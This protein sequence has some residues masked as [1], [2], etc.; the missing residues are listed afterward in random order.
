MFAKYLCKPERIVACALKTYSEIGGIQQFN[1]RVF[2]NLARRSADKKDG[3][4]LAILSGDQG[5][6]PP[7][8][9]GIEF[10]VP[11]NQVQFVATALWMSVFRAKALI[12]CHVNLLPLA[13]AVRQFRPRLPIVL[14]VH[15]C[16]VWNIDRP[17][18]IRSLETLFAR[19]A[20]RIAAVSRFT[21][22]CMAREY[23]IAPDKFRILPNAVDR[24]HE[25]PAA[26]A[27]EPRTILT[28]ARL[29]LTERQKNVHF[30][31]AA[32]AVLR[33]RLPGVK[34]EIIGG[35]AL[36]PELQALAERLEVADAVT[37]FGQVG[38]REVREAYARA[39]VFAMP[40]DK[41]GFGIVYLE[42]WQHAKPVIC[43][44]HGAASEIV[45]EGVD[46][47][48]VDP[49]D[50]NLLAERLFTLLTRPDVARAM[51]LSGR[52]KVEEKYLNANF[53]RHLDKIL[54]EVLLDSVQL[55]AASDRRPHP[56]F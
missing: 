4:A 40:S 48:V 55:T 54:D 29:G 31:L 50:V 45:A 13:F 52:R 30:M 36:L 19:S 1:R 21:A 27:P 33:R 14:F 26:S 10:A 56:K 44:S 49:A 39:A 37:F 35:G 38:D 9:D 43:S 17:R 41:E 23:R 16:E 25:E 18:K 12:I 5:A 34:Y 28:V 46:G 32:I 20:T 42:A 53:R 2:M 22:D 6:A 15:G 7:A 24:L 47:F 8:I 11:G 51:G 3:P